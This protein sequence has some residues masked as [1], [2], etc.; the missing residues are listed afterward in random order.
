MKQRETRRWRVSPRNTKTN[1][2]HPGRDSIS[3]PQGKDNHGAN[4]SPDLAS[5]YL[6]LLLTAEDRNG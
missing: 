5:S 1:R 4:R 6:E 2:S 3:H